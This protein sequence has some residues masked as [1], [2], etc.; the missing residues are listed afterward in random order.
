[1]ARVSAI[2]STCVLAAALTHTAAAQTHG[3]LWVRSD[4]GAGWIG[5]CVSLGAQGTQVFTEIEFGQD[6]AEL[7]SGFDT[8][9]PVPVW[10][11]ALPVEGANSF[12]D[13]AEMV[14][15]HVSVHQIVL[16]NNNSTKQTVISKYTSASSTPNWTYTF[17]GTTA[18]NARVSI[19]DD[20]QRI[21]AGNYENLSNQLRLAVFTPSS[22]TPI[23]TGTIANFS[24]G[25]RGWDLSSD[26][27]LLYAAS[28]AMLTIFN[29]STHASVAQY[30]LMSSI[31]GCHSMSGDGR[32]FAQGGFNFLDVWERNQSGTYT[33]TYTRNLAGSYVCTHVDISSNGASIAYSF[34]GYDTNNHVRIE[35]LDVATKQITMSD[36]AVGSG[37]LQN[38]CSDIAMSQDGTHFVVGLWGDEADVCPEV[39][40]YRNNQS[41]PVALHNLSGSVYDVDISADGEHVA[42]AAKAV[43][44]NLYAGGGSIRYYAFEQQDIRCT[45]VPSPGSTVQFALQGPDS[46]PARLLWATAQATTP[47]P[48]GNVGLLYLNRQLMHTVAIPATSTT[49]A[50]TASYALPS[51]AG[52]IGSTLY[53]QGY[54]TDPRRLTHD[55]V[56]VTLV[57]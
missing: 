51:G 16:N 19:S 2:I 8:N 10:Q 22:S 34:N 28:A 54:F 7:L 24:M 50:T 21:V 38:V 18:G 48:F 40:F 26:G 55:F 47:T 11:N 35:C 12:V 25:I 13:S 44:A 45:G 52:Q 46:S 17:P 27:S 4:N 36:E 3:A 33:K 57:P 29:T 32:V 31:D 5:H 42:V 56:R 53:F 1:M 43:H 37:T 20:G 14:D 9:P 49:G 23:W 15:I 39:R 41:V 30:V 6:H